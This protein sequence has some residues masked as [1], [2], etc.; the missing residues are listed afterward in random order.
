M[1]TEMKYPC[2]SDMLEGDCKLY[3]AAMAVLDAQTGKQ[4]K[5]E[6]TSLETC[7]RNGKEAVEQVSAVSKTGNILKIIS[8]IPL[9]VNIIA[10]IILGIYLI[11]FAYTINKDKSLMYKI[12]Q[13]LFALF[14]QPIYVLHYLYNI[15]KPN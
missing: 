12:G 4:C 11:Y 6:F 7:M 3:N 5:A 14:F 9:V 10:S 8:Y 13:V 1:T 15:P 2:P